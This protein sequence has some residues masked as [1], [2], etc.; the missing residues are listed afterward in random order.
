MAAR[1]ASASFSIQTEGVSSEPHSPCTDAEI[2]S[3]RS[4]SAT[5]WAS[6]EFD[7]LK[8]FFIGDSELQVAHLQQK[9]DD[10]MTI[11]PIQAG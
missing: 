8:I 10:L 6:A 5:R 9:G 4:A 2:P 7:A 1:W 3:C 11:A